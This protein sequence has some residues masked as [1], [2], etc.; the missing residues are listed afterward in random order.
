MQAE[1]LARR[2]KLARGGL[3]IVLCVDVTEKLQPTEG[4]H[5]G[6]GRGFVH[7]SRCRPRF[8]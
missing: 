5:A 1:I 6:F 3:A 8:R 7:S 2:R 4:W